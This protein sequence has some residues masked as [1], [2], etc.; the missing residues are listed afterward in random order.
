MLRINLECEVV[1]Q[2][3]DT[4]YWHREIITDRDVFLFLMRFSSLMRMI[5]IE[6]EEYGRAKEQDEMEKQGELPF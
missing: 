3:Q 1:A 4:G 5:V 6:S 2:D